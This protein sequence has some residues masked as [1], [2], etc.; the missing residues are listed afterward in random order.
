[1]FKDSILHLAFF[2]LV[3]IAAFAVILSLSLL[4]VW[5]GIYNPFFSP[6]P[7]WLKL[8]FPD[9]AG[10]ALLASVFASFYLLFFRIKK[11]P[12]NKLLSFILP[13]IAAFAILLLG[14]N[15]VYGPAGNIP[16]R[17]FA[18]LNPF[19]PETIHQ[20]D[21]A[22]IY[23]DAV[24]RRDAETGIRLENVLVYSDGSMRHFKQ[25]TAVV[26]SSNGIAQTMI[27]PDELTQE[28]VTMTPA[29][30]V[31]QPAFN[32]PAVIASLTRDID[33]LNG[34][35]LDI[36]AKSPGKFTLTLFSVLLSA[37]GCIFFSRFSSWPLFNALLTLALFRGL[38]LLSRFLDSD[39]GREISGMIPNQ[40]VSEMFLAIVFLALGLLLMAANFAFL[41]KQNG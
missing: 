6:E 18:A 16:P 20:T 41:G 26:R 14:A 34:Y 39:I 21:D 32:P 8:Q 25:A 4:A 35:L 30:P 2:C 40:F 17:G 3:F 9:T 31:Y 15:V 38:F 11:K 5:A 10:K 24:S 36:R 1:M 29:N 27:L 22:S 12:G 19:I 28:P 13:P 23:V 7:G 33:I 37:M